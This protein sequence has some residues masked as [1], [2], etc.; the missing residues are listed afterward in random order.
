MWRSPAPPG[1]GPDAT[2]VSGPDGDDRTDPARSRSNWSVQSWTM[3]SPF[4]P[5][6]L[7]TRPILRRSAEP[8]PNSVVDDV[9]AGLDAVLGAGHVDQGADRLRGAATAADDPTHVLGGHVQVQAH[10]TP[11]LFG[12]DHHGLGVVRQRL[13]E[14][15]QHRQ[16]RAP[17]ERGPFVAHAGLVA[18][19]GDL[20]DVVAVIQVVDVVH[21]VDVVVDVV[22]ARF[23]VELVVELVVGFGPGPGAGPTTAAAHLVDVARLV[24]IRHR[25]LT[26]PWRPRTRP[27]RRSSSKAV[28][29]ARWAG[30]R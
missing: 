10:A 5:W 11:P 21:V 22:V 13:G 23:V 26:S 7:V 16:R 30:R 3:T 6:A 29:P 17:V 4:R 2:T 14:I 24:Q 8:D 9:H 12:F 28:R 27:T 19:A 25:V 15:R 1:P 18:L 20:L